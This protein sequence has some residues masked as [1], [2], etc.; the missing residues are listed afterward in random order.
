MFHLC[1]EAL[2]WTKLSHWY[3]NARFFKVS[4][5]SNNIVFKHFRS[6]QQSICTFAHG[7]HTDWW[8]SNLFV[9]FD[10]RFFFVHIDLS[11]GIPSSVYPCDHFSQV[12]NHIFVSVTKT[13]LTRFLIIER[14]SWSCNIED[15]IEDYQ[16]LKHF[17]CCR[18]ISQWL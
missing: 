1:T 9:G 15:N 3:R 14:W 5:P 17:S 13:F 18:R 11:R 10:R 12:Y 16:W 4:V 8:L 6:Q 7:F 2:W